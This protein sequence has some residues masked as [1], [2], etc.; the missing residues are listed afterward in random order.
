MPTICLRSG[1]AVTAE[2]DGTVTIRMFGPIAARLR[3]DL[4]TV[5]DLIDARGNPDEVIPICAACNRLADLA[6]VL[7]KEET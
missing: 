4:K 3:K 2:E 7:P 1:I 5:T 6:D